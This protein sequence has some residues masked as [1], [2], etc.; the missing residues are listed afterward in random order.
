MEDVPGFL[1]G[2][3]LRSLESS[4]WVKLTEDL[5]HH[6]LRVR[7]LCLPC[8]V[9]RREF[10]VVRRLRIRRL[11]VRCP[12]GHAK[13]LRCAARCVRCPPPRVQD[14]FA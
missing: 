12:A 11:V 13:S 6:R 4:L 8:L 14:A 1:A 7:S 5:P 9:K 3:G 10:V 2:M